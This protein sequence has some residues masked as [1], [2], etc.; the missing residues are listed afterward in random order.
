MEQVEKDLSKKNEYSQF[1]LFAKSNPSFRTHLLFRETANKK[2]KVEKYNL[3]DC[4]AI[5]DDALRK[6]PFHEILLSIFKSTKQ[7]LV[8]G[9]EFKQNHW[10]TDIKLVLG[11]TSALIAGFAAWYNWRKSFQ[12]SRVVLITCVV[13]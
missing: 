10:H 7:V 12:E 11:Y 2:L 6:V 3:V 1:L 13:L 9:M 4:K 8:E 5:L